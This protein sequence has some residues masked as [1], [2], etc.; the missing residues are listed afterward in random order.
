M[1]RLFIV[2][3]TGFLFFCTVR[4][5]AY[6]AACSALVRKP[7]TIANECGEIS[8]ARRA[9]F[10]SGALTRASF[11][12]EA[13]SNFIW[14]LCAVSQV[15]ALARSDRASDAPSRQGPS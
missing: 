15:Q 10:P 8:A 13:A 4:P 9:S 2:H 5:F 11:F 7:C 1:W 6:S 14:L 3:V 12:S